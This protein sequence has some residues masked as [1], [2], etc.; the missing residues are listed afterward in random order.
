M[1]QQVLRLLSRPMAIGGGRRRLAPAVSP[2]RR[3]RWTGGRGSPSGRRARL[4]AFRLGRWRPSS[5]RPPWWS[6]WSYRSW[7]MSASAASRQS[8]LRRLLPDRDRIPTSGA[9]QAGSIPCDH[10]STRRCTTTHCCRFSIKAGC[11]DPYQPWPHRGLLL[12]AAHAHRRAGDH[13]RRVACDRIFTLGDFFQVW[14]AWTGSPQPLDSTHV[15][16]ITLSS[17][18]KL[19]VYLDGGD[20]AGPVAFP[21]RPE[22]DRAEAARDHHPGGHAPMVSPPSQFPSG[23]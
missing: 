16:S 12:L 4:R 18:E 20:G 5:R 14:G 9:G 11:G 21:R 19:L 22:S 2:D 3:W 15:S 7:P 10:S 23:F 8:I 13:P 1:A 17:N 6:S